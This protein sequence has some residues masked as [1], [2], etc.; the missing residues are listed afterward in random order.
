MHLLMLESLHAVCIGNRL[1]PLVLLLLAL[2]ASPAFSADKQVVFLHLNDLHAH[3]V[4]HQDLVRAV[5]GN[6][7][8]VATTETRGGLARLATLIR[9]AR[10][11][12]P[13]QTLLMNVGDTYHGGVEALY[14][15]GNAVIAP[16]DALGIDI[17][18][19]GN[20]DFAYGPIVTRLRYSTGSSWLSQLIN[21]VVYGEA[22]QRPAYPLLGGNVSKSLGILFEDEPL[23]PTTYTLQVG[24]IKVGFIGIT[25]DIVPRM[26]PTLALGFTFL[27]GHD[28]Y[29]NLINRATKELRAQGAHLVVVMSELGI[30]RDHQLANSIDPGVDVFFS[31]HTHELTTEPLTSTSGAL[32]VES[33]DDAYLGRMTVSFRDAQPIQFHW[34]LLQ[35]TDDIPE[36]AAMASLVDAARAPFLAEVVHFDYP[37]PN[38][39]FP[40]DARIDTVITES[41]LTLNRRGVLANS[42]NQYLAQEMRSHYHTDV[43]LAPGFRFDAVVAPGDAITLETLYRYLPVPATLAKGNITAANLKALFEKELTRVFSSDAFQHSGGWFLG[44]SGLDVEVDLARGDGERV[45]SM[46]RAPNG[47]EIQAD[48]VLTVAS[49]VRPLDKPGV[50]CSGE[51]F[52]DVE[53]LL[54]PD[55]RETTP[56]RFLQQ[57][58]AEQPAQPPTGGVSDV[59]NAPIWPIAEFMQP[60]FN[61]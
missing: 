57:R 51:G 6:G 59:S 33:G 21:T 13:G 42:F 17:G 48:D 26:S 28:A 41:A 16:V 38:T 12:A 2:Q 24:D 58:L 37:M 11:E 49:C 53:V 7:Q 47:R 34:E 54:D 60:L 20:W 32:L 55:G 36:D 18:V 61:L 22:V 40:L 4:P 10:E 3:L 56:L 27:Q 8:P 15:R 52:T 31:A 29:N 46:R 45:I 35:V 50:L 14:T 39:D 5:S 19:P 23:L 43:A 30:H 25:S 9:Q 44:V 1:A